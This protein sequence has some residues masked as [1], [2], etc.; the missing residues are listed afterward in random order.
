MEKQTLSPAVGKIKGKPDSPMGGPGSP[1][2]TFQKTWPV[3]LNAV[4]LPESDLNSPPTR[5]FPNSPITPWLPFLTSVLFFISC[6]KLEFPWLWG[7]TAGLEGETAP[8]CVAWKCSAGKHKL[9]HLQTG[10]ADLSMGCL[11]MVPQSWEGKEEGGGEHRLTS[12]PSPCRPQN[13][14]A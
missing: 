1:V 4:K 2:S 7:G 10:E 13:Y 12:Q 3:L 5:P 6:A 9:N 14:A 8:A 11:D